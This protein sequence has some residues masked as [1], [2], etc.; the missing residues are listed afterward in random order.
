MEQGGGKCAIMNNSEKN[1]YVMQQIVQATVELLKQQELSDISIRQ[2]T[3]KAEVSRNSFYRNYKD[4]EDILFSYVRNLLTAWREEY[5]K[6]N[7]DSNAALYGSLFAHFKKYS[8]FYILLK[9]RGLFHLLLKALLQEAGA[10]PDHDNMAAYVISFVAHSGLVFMTRPYF[11]L[12]Q[13]WGHLET[14]SF[15]KGQRHIR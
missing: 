1:S 9:K 15:P 11:A 8:D 6:S 4:K 14:W 12:E 7:Q 13:F 2:I 3:E 5:D 10:K